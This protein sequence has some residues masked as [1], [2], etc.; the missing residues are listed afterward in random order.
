M[1]TGKILDEEGHG[2][3]N[4]KVSIHNSSQYGSVLTDENGSYVIPAEGGRYITVRYEK[5][6]Y[7]TIDRKVYGQPED[8][9]IAEDVTM[10]KIDD[11]VTTINLTS[12]TP[13]IHSSSIVT[14]DR[15]SRATTLVFNGVTQ[16]TVKSPD[17]STRVLDSLDVRATEF[18]TPES[19]PS[20]LPIETAYT[21]CSDLT[22][23][24]VKDDET[25]EFNAP[26]IM[27]VDNFLGFDVGEIV[28]IGYYDR[29]KGEWIGSKKMEQL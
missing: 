20:D 29:N 12:S 24:G 25:V 6:G 9:A 18:K 27:Y 21:Y 4:V 23:D 11:K 28:P 2:L 16:A 19:M 5:A 17:G 3:S 7:T 8:W 14:D 15:G 1:L 26:V 22:V 13:Q 10:L